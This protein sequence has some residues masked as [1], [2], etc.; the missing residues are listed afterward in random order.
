ME[1]SAWER[2]NL[3]RGR[4]AGGLKVGDDCGTRLLHTGQLHGLHEV[5]E[6]ELREHAKAGVVL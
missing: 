3:Q 6:D 1:R 2:G 5:V 4:G